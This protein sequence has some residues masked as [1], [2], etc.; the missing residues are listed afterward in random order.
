MRSHIPVAGVLLQAGLSLAKPYLYAKDGMVYNVL[1]REGAFGENEAAI[2]AR[3][4]S[5]E[6]ANV[7]DS[8]MGSYNLIATGTGPQPTGRPRYRDP[9]FDFFDFCSS[10][11][12]PTKT[13]TVTTRTSTPTPPVVTITVTATRSSTS[14]R[15]TTNSSPPPPPTTKSTSTPDVVTVTVT[16]T[17]T[18]TSTKPTT[19][20][21]PPTTST[22]SKF[23]TPTTTS[24]TS[25]SSPAPLPP[26]TTTTST[27]PSATG[28]LCPSAVAGQICGV[29][30][31]G[32]AENNLYSG[33]PIDAATCHQLCLANPDCKSFQTQD[34]SYEAPQCNLYK[35]DASGNNTIPGA[36]PYL[37][38][39][40]G[41]PDYA[42]A[43]CTKVA[44]PATT[45][46]PT[47]TVGFGLAER[48]WGGG[49]PQS[50]TLPW[51]LDPFGPETISEVC[52]CII[53]LAPPA[54]GYTTTVRW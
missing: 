24:T 28:S 5:L 27:P 43:A 36:A 33:S 10:F 6:Q 15:S 39:D 4:M 8:C 49:K 45:V 47:L 53:T 26:S 40:R 32:Y 23:S 21:L 42:P 7:A 51:F 18:S 30:G 34:S 3:G 50:V 41:C 20:L 19:T 29:P 54:I 1:P 22:T 38:Y 12:R 11:I 46:K 52:S 17:R 31:W 9:D 13:Y 48:Q 16:A 14:T 35:V 2:E 44:P 37:F 25:S